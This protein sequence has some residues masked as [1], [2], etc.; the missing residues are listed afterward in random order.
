MRVVPGGRGKR[1]NEERE[2]RRRERRGLL[3]KIHI[4][5]NELGLSEDL[6]REILIERYGVDTAAELSISQ[7][8]DLVAYFRE[9]G[10]N[11]KRAERS[12]AKALQARVLSYREALGAKRVAGVCEKILGVSDPRWCQDLGKLRRACAVLHKIYREEAR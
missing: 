4:A 5:K 7:M 9:C 1:L 3:A 11:E 2:R 6:Y 10:W 12:R 8:E